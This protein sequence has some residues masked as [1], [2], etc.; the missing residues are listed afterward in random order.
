[1]QSTSRGLTKHARGGPS[2]KKIIAELVLFLTD[3]QRNRKNN[4]NT[5]PP[6][7]NTP[8][9]RTRRRNKSTRSRN[10]A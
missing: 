3:T 1:M 9:K 10:R 8:V 6:R 7:Y 4:N 2:L 5:S